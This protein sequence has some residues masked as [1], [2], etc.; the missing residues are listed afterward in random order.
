MNPL[1]QRKAIIV[2]ER[3][4]SHPITAPFLKPVECDDGNKQTS[5]TIITDTLKSNNYSSFQ[6]WIDDIEK[7]WTEIENKYLADASNDEKKKYILYLSSESRKLFQKEKKIIDILSITN[8][9]AE[10]CRLRSKISDQLSIPPPK[11]K[12]D[13]IAIGTSRL[14]K[15][16][17][18]FLNEKELDNFIK[19]TEMMQ[20]DEEQ[21]ELQRIIQENQSELLNNSYDRIDVTKLNMQTIQQLITYMKS[22]IEKRGEHYPE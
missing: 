17:V 9:G 21:S 4:M 19:A 13:A 8:W 20:S 5:L 22:V 2:M 10:V 16:D 6:N 15:Q 7:C 11:I 14:A 1:L 18:T 3:L 12:P